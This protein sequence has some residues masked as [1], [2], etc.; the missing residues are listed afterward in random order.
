MVD[1]V[2][3]VEGYRF[4]AS[5]VVSYYDDTDYEDEYIVNCKIYIK[6]KKDGITI[7][8]GTFN[9]YYEE[10]RKYIKEAQ[11]KIGETL[12]IIDRQM[13]EYQ[14]LVNEFNMLKAQSGGFN[15]GNIRR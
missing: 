8:Y 3:K 6:L 11:I 1:L 9:S 12:N 2:I 15:S 7:D 13:D 10:N 4:K 5:D 14:R